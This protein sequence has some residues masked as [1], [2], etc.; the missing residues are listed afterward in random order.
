LGDMVG[1]IH[2]PVVTAA[3]SFSIYK[4]LAFCWIHPRIPNIRVGI[5][6]GEIVVG[7]SCLDRLKLGFAP[8]RFTSLFLYE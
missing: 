2:G 7:L 5:L 4:L 1:G 8:C 6:R 3:A